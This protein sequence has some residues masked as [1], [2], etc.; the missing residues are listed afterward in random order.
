MRNPDKQILAELM[1]TTGAAWNPEGMACS[2]LSLLKIAK[3]LLNLAPVHRD[4]KRQP[5]SLISTLQDC[6]R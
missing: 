5:G 4:S 3:E 6:L 2:R 1:P